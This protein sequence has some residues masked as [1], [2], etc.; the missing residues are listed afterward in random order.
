MITFDILWRVSRLYMYQRMLRGVKI[1]TYFLIFI[2]V[3]QSDWTLE[4]NVL[5]MPLTQGDAA[6]YFCSEL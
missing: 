6:V 1:V 5:F 2:I 4:F 3:S